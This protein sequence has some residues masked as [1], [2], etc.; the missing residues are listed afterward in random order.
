[1]VLSTFDRASVAVHDLCEHAYTVP[2]F[3]YLKSLYGDHR[4]SLHCGDS[5]ET[6]EQARGAG[7]AL[8]DAVHIDGGHDFEVAA[9][10]L[11]NARALAK[12]G[13][14]VI[15]DD[16]ELLEVNA[17][18]SYAKDLGFVVTEREGL[19]WKENCYGRYST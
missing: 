2:N 17:A 13:A 7:R 10:D 16:C 8:W 18:W 5:R 4:V 11:V 12:G 3:E 9:A 14:L 6:L 15:L 19:C 1:M